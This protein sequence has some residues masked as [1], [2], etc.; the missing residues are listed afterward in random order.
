[1]NLPSDDVYITFPATFV[2]DKESSVAESKLNLR[3]AEVLTG[4][5]NIDNPF[6]TDNLFDVGSSMPSGKTDNIPFSVPVM[7][8]WERLSP[9]IPFP[10]FKGNSPLILP[11]T[12][13]NETTSPL[14]P[15]KAELFGE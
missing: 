2:I 12:S 3:I 13:L 14:F 9:M 15:R 6:I 1:V 4:F 10:T 7:I 11:T 5:G 8:F